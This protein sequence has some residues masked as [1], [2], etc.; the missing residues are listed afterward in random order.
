MPELTAPVERGFSVSGA[1]APDGGEAGLLF[2]FSSDMR[3]LAITNI[4]R[5]A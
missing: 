5:V 4:I 3:S 2:S 1:R